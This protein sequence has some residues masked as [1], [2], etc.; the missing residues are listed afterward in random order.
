[1]ALVTVP[2]PSVNIEDAEENDTNT[3]AATAGRGKDEGTWKRRTHKDGA[4]STNIT[5]PLRMRGCQ[6]APLGTISLKETINVPNSQVKQEEE[7]MCYCTILGTWLTELY[8]Q[9]RER[10][11]NLNADQ[12]QQRKG[13]NHA[14][15]T[16]N[17]ALLHQF[18]SSL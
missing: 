11:D 14:T 7:G 18:L 12:Q 6:V 9:E 10:V 8:L 17:P 1:M 4:S 5:I 16:L 15:T 2:L 3:Q 13:R